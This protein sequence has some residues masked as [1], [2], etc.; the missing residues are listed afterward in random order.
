MPAMRFGR[1]ITTSLLSRLSKRNSWQAAPSRKC[2]RI[3]S[4]RQWHAALDFINKSISSRRDAYVYQVPNKK[5]PELP[6]S[7]AIV[8]SSSLW[9]ICETEK[10]QCISRERHDGRG[11]IACVLLGFDEV[12]TYMA[13]YTP[14]SSVMPSSISSQQD[15]QGLTPLR[16]SL[17]LLLPMTNS[18]LLL[19]K[20]PGI[21]LPFPVAATFTSVGDRRR[22]RLAPPALSNF[23][24]SALGSS[25]FTLSAYRE[26]PSMTDR[27]DHLWDLV[28]GKDT[29]TLGYRVLRAQSYWASR[30]GG[31][32]EVDVRVS[33][34]RLT[35]LAK[36]STFNA[37][38]RTSTNR[39]FNNLRVRRWIDAHRWIWKILTDSF[40]IGSLPPGP[41]TSTTH[42][43][44]FNSSYTSVDSTIKESARLQVNETANPEGFEPTSTITLQTITDHTLTEDHELHRGL[45]APHLR[46]LLKG[47]MGAEL[48]LTN[49]ILA[50]F[51]PRFE[52]S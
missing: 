8:P 17:P 16:P 52:I 46:S 6:P 10:T 13:T 43:L 11:G 49:F 23:V 19:H 51:S 24:V 25:Q 7:I 41:R 28:D 45:S 29:M 12:Q 20:I 32:S 48:L 15:R 18:G 42:A 40:C 36:S 39:S 1:C 35:A 14:F 47:R 31:P 3:F 50:I 2:Y 33:N 30:V 9:S 21:R 26:K 22:I 34:H 44:Q 4:D 37:C 27:L 38:L 5:S